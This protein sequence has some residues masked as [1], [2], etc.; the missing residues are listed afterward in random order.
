MNKKEKGL[1]LLF[2]VC[3]N[4]GRKITY[5]SEQYETDFQKPTCYFFCFILFLRPQS[6]VHGKID[7]QNPLEKTFEIMCVIL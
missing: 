2:Q 6:L 7:R 3:K 5:V 1:T 4:F